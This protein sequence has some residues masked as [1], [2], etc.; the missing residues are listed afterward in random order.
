MANN[1]GAGFEYY[2]YPQWSTAL[3]WIIFICCVIPIP[4]VYIVNYIREFRAIPLRR[5]VR[6]SYFFFN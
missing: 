1:A 5:L 4:I 2:A 3:G 6:E